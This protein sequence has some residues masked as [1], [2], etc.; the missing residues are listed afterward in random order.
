MLIRVTCAI[1]EVENRV[2]VV[3]RSKE[4]SMPLK[5]EFP[6]GKIESGEC[7]EECIVREIK[8]E[9]NLEI[10]DLIKLCSSIFD[11]PSISI[12]LIPF[13]VKQVRGQIKLNEHA[14]FLYLTKYKLLDLDWA[15]ADIP[16]VKEYLNL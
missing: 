12:E 7:E 13:V 2:L 16:I 4:M 6:G 10:S 11:Y 8:E 3:Q 5:W 1:I 9:L 15:E 14:Y